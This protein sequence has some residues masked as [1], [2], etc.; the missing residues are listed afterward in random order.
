MNP[1]N[2]KYSTFRRL[3]T[4]SFFITLSPQP[5]LPR[6]FRPPHSRI[7]STS[8][9]LFQ[10]SWPVFSKRRPGFSH[11]RRLQCT[12]RI[13]FEKKQ[14]SLLPMSENMRTFAA[15]FRRIGVWCN[16]NTADSGPAFPGS[17][18][19]TPTK[20]RQRAFLFF[21]RG[22]PEDT[23]SPCTTRSTVSFSGRVPA[24]VFFS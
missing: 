10:N 17:N 8:R 16:G 7:I 3:N 12:K 13:F 22:N 6:H 23:K 4:C 1:N 24:N 9:L 14:P 5:P 19:G 15:Q 21:Y 11:Q 2:C 18:P 20:E